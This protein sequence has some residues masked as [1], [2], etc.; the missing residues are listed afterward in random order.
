MGE[1]G[2]ANSREDNDDDPPPAPAGF[3]IPFRPTFTD[4]AAHRPPRKIAIA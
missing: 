4:A 1:A 2:R 3:G